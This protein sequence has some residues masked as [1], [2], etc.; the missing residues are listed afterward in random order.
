MRSG[1]VFL[2]L[3]ALL[4]AGAPTASAETL[5]HMYSP[6]TVD[7]IELTLPP[8]SVA[9]L[10]ADPDEYVE[11]TF[12]LAET[13]GTP[14]GIGPTSAPLTVGI[15]LKGEGSFQGL[16]GRAS[17]KVKFNELVKK[18]TFLGLKKMTLNNLA[19]D[20]SMVHEALAYEAFRAA[21]IVAPRTGFASV[22]LNGEDFGIHLN[23]ETMD[24]VALE[25]H[26]GVFEDPPQ[27]LYEGGVDADV[28]QAGLAEF[29]VDEGDDEDI[30]DLEA[31]ADAYAAEEPQSFL[32]RMAPVADLE[33]MTRM[34]AVE[35]YIAHWDGY[36][37]VAGAKNFYLYS[38]PDGVF[39]MLPWGTDQTWAQPEHSFGG[40]GGEMFK[41]CLADQGCR[42]L[43]VTAL[44]GVETTITDLGLVAR[45]TAIA[46][47]LKPW[48]ELEAG[49]RRL[50]SAEK[51][52]VGVSA[53]REFIADRPATLESWLENRPAP[54]PETEPEAT[55]RSDPPMAPG[56][57][58]VF[59]G[60]A[61]IDRSKLSRGVLVSTISVPAAGAVEQVARVA[62]ATGRIACTA[63]AT[64]TSAADVTLRCRLSG[65]VR[66]RLA[67]RRLRLSISTSFAHDRPG[68]G[69]GDPLD[70][71]RPRGGLGELRRH[72]LRAV[73]VQRRELLLRHLQRVRQL[74]RGADDEPELVGIGVVEQLPGRI[75]LDQ[76]RVKR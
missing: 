25:K 76:Q 16:E 70:P 42:A 47:L 45:A 38:G 74:G 14:D 26:Y 57:T 29:E 39:E 17:F 7:V 53:T 24:A 34:W 66:R 49:P 58:P 52:A 46:A 65:A 40:N 61:L 69:N 37:A 20:P 2:A 41:A 30:A 22:R 18:Q 63:R 9:A 72:R 15:R 23:L 3:A 51:I 64:T 44:E 48:Q 4:A 13:D 67:A 56:V 31:L 71:A 55:P 8:D 6:A 10:E 60:R 19:Q 35:K 54:E 68:T 59:A 1:L 5:D 33:Q 50:Y 62:T 75:G 27:H 11:G 21:G 28:D 43:Y 12:A 73:R 36:A 32:E